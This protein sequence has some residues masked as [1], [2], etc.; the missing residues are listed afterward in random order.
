MMSV[1]HCI[2][3]CVGRNDTVTDTVRV[4][5]CRSHNDGRKCLCCVCLDNDTVTGTVTQ[6]HTASA[7][8][9]V[10]E[11]LCHCATACIH[12]NTSD[13]HIHTVP[14]T[15]KHNSRALCRS[16]NAVGV[17][18]CDGLF[19]CVRVHNDTHCRVL[20]ADM[21]YLLAGTHRHGLFTKG[22]P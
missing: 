20:P 16:H 15:V 12:T 8:T 3:V 7:V 13:S 1:F 17:C 6:S 18:V 22:T 11:V 2:T 5:H 10:E 21:N 4:T 9:T 14:H 19:H